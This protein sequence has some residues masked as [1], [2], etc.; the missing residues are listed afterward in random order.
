MKEQHEETKQ[1]LL[2][3]AEAAEAAAIAEATAAAE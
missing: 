3:E 1:R 2:E